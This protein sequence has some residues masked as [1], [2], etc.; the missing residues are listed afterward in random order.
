MNRTV[1]V[2]LTCIVLLLSFKSQK[3]TKTMPLN[4]IRVAAK[5]QPAKQAILVFHGLGDSGSGWSF[6]AEYLQRDPK[7]A[8]TRFVFPNAPTMAI[9]AN[10]GMAMPAWFNI[11]EWGNPNA[12]ID[13]PGIK[14][15]L[16]IINA[17][18]QE[19]IDDGIAPENIV[20]GGFSQ[21]AA[22]SL[23]TAV[24]SPHKLAGFFALSGFSRLNK[25]DLESIENN[26]NKDTP[27]FHGHGDMDPVISIQSGL[28]AKK[29]YEEHYEIKDYTFRA[30]QGM[31]HSTCA[32]EMSDLTEFLY[33]ALEL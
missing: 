19:Q 23:A 3:L 27:I 24:S 2:I 21:G 13:V 20:V 22:L 25:E 28:E 31:A 14:S 5:A 11:Y 7:F 29:F 4:A 12:K 15:S 9:D 33:K 6:L 32:Q 8:H 18:V 26:V 1:L 30:Y 16:N 10:G 17:F